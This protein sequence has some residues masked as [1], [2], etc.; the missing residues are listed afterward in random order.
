MDYED[1]CKLLSTADLQEILGVAIEKTAEIMEGSD[2]C[3]WYASSTGELRS[4]D[5]RR[6]LSPHFLFNL[7]IRLVLRNFIQGH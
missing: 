7:L 1:S 4:P 5:R 3:T 2:P 6:R